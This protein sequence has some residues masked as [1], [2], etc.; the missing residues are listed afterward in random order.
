MDTSKKRRQNILEKSFLIEI[1]AYYHL[2]ILL[3]FDLEMDNWPP[4]QAP[5]DCRFVFLVLSC[6]N[7][8]F[9][10]DFGFVKEFDF[11]KLIEGSIEFWSFST[12]AA[13]F[14]WSISSKKNLSLVKN[15]N[16]GEKSKF[17]LK[18]E[19]LDKNRNFG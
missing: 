2:S 8:D 3:N 11:K 10:P 13:S 9:L 12:A 14:R 7:P 4:F 18:L 16:F 15:R 17:W 6:Q 5:I 19:I 1:N